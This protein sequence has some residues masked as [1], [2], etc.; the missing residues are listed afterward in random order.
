MGAEEHRP[1]TPLPQR[2]AVRLSTR[3]GSPRSSSP[4]ALP[5]HS[6]LLHFPPPA[7]GMSAST[8]CQP[9][10]NPSSTSCIQSGAPSHDQLSPLPDK[11]RSD[12]PIPPHK[13]PK[14][15]TPH[16]VNPLPGRKVEPASGARWS[17]NPRTPGH[18]Q[19]SHP[20][21][22][23]HPPSP[24]APAL[25]SPR[26]P[27]LSPSLASATRPR[28]WRVHTRGRVSCA[29]GSAVDRKTPSGWRTTTA[30]PTSCPKC[31]ECVLSIG[32]LTARRHGVVQKTQHARTLLPTLRSRPRAAILES[33]RAQPAR[34][35]LPPSGLSASGQVMP[36]LGA[37]GSGL[38]HG[39]G[40]GAGGTGTG[41]G[42]EA[43]A[44]ARGWRLG[45]RGSSRMLR[46]AVLARPVGGLTRTYPR[47]ATVRHSPVIRNCVDERARA[48]P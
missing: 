16:P 12:P 29:T 6:T 1:S 2:F 45:A 43:R 38:G 44:R 7:S 24:P 19:P 21:C 33:G 3:A 31:R 18:Q 27:F 5:L 17:P 10:R 20:S 15:A 4:S 8:I 47:V 37:R 14:I 34:T 35:L 30:T 36:S 48:A 46:P 11:P 26:P 39:H 40:H 9:E 32:V 42:L 13:P 22:L 25:A 28:S 23:G 41:S